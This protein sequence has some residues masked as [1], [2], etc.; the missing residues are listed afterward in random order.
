[1]AIILG[2]ASNVPMHIK[3]PGPLVSS[4]LPN[5]LCMCPK[6]GYPLLDNLD[7]FNI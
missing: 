4:P 6:S 2:M 5:K 7:W 3:H 1:M